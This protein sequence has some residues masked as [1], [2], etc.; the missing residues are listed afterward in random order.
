MAGRTAE[1]WGGAHAPRRGLFRAAA[2]SRLNYLA[3]WARGLGILDLSP[4]YS[5]AVVDAQDSYVS[6]VHDGARKILLDP[7]SMGAVRYTHT[8]A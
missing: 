5:F 7:G 6:I 8:N 4:T 1:Y 3:A 2:G